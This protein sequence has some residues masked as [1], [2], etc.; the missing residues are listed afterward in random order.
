MKKLLTA[1]TVALLA[2]TAAPA[3][4]A[5]L[6]GVQVT[7]TL[8]Y[9]DQNTNYLGQTPV[10]TTVSSG[11]EFA[12]GFFGADGG[13][14]VGANTVTFITNHTGGYGGGTFNGYRLDF[15]GRKVTSFSLANGNTYQ[16]A[17]SFSGSSVFIN[18]L[19]TSADG[20]NVVFD[21]Q[22]SAVPEPATWAMMMLGFGMV[23]F[24]LRSRPK[25]SVRVTYA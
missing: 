12:P 20:G 16:P 7:G 14:D 18:V 3:L 13:I 19:G 15:A 23:G 8:L 2:S 25:S 17:A 10:T 24:G 5:D 22:T 4:A 1:A 6:I 11:V 9:P 21:I